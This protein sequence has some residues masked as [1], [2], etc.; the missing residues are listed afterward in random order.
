MIAASQAS[1]VRDNLTEVEEDDESEIIVRPKDEADADTKRQFDASEME[2]DIEIPVI[3][4][5]LEASKAYHSYQQSLLDIIRDT[6]V[7]RTAMVYIANPAEGQLLLQDSSTAAESIPPQNVIK[8][9]GDNISR[10]FKK[11]Q[12]VLWS[13][14]ED[15]ELPAMHYEEKQ[16]IQSFLGVPIRYNDHVIGVLA[17]DSEVQQ[18]YSS[19]DTV[20]LQQYSKLIATAMRQFD[21]IDKLQEERL[22]YAQLCEMNTSLTTTYDK[23]ELLDKI[24]HINRNLFDYDRMA[25]VLLQEKNSMQAELAATDG[26]YEGYSDGYRFELSDSF[27]RQALVTGKAQLFQSIDEPHNAY[28]LIPE[29]SSP[30]DVVRSMLIVPIKN[31]KESYGLIVLQSAQNEKFNS[32]D[33]E[34]LNMIGS[35]FGAGLNRFYLYRYMNHIASRDGLTGIYNYRTFRDRLEEEIQRSTRYQNRFTL[36]IADLDNFKRINDTHGHL[37][38]DYMLKEV[39]RIIRNSV[40][41]VDIVARYGGEEFAIV[42]INSSVSTAKITAARIQKSIESYDFQYDNISENITISIG[43]AEFPFHGDDAETLTSRA[44]QAMYEVKKVGG[45]AIKTYENVTESKRV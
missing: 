16:R 45:N 26:E 44:D 1:H 43:M 27:M 19:E 7:S 23:D 39:A 30:E 31:H 20:L 11:K 14:N 41:G 17:V 8:L 34:I 37:Y 10:V 5:E 24:T 36:C 40:R 13:I 6:L 32:Q 33:E 38:G 15:E 21:I 2:P 3:S 18:S 9:N 4:D 42:L 12:S 25:I 22:F 29:L 35:V 28:T